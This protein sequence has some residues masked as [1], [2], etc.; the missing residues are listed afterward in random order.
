[1]DLKFYKK[2]P[3]LSRLNNIN[4]MKHWKH[5]GAKEHRLCGKNDFYK[6]YPEFNLEDYKKN[7]Q[8]KFKNDDFYLLNWHHYDTENFRN[9]KTNL[10]KISR[11]QNKLMQHCNRLYSDKNIPIET[12]ESLARKNKLKNIIPIK[13][14]ENI[15]NINAN[16]KNENKNDNKDISTKSN[17]IM[18]KD[19][20][21][22]FYKEYSDL[23]KFNGRQLSSHW[24]HHGQYENRIYSKEH[25]Y[26]I[27]PYFDIDRFK[28]LSDKNYKNDA[29]IMID[30]YHNGDKTDKR[31]YSQIYNIKNK[32]TPKCEIFRNHTL[33][34]KKIGRSILKEKKEKEK[35]EK[36]EKEKKEKEKIEKYKKMIENQVKQK[37]LKSKQEQQQLQQRQQYENKLKELKA[38]DNKID[39]II[40]NKN[41]LNKIHFDIPKNK[42]IK[43]K[44]I[45]TE[46]KENIKL[47][48]EQKELINDKMFDINFY[49]KYWDLKQMNIEQLINHWLNFGQ[50]ENRLGSIAH[51]KLLYPHFNL[52]FFKSKLNEI[53]SEDEYYYIKKHHTKIDNSFSDSITPKSS[54][55]KE[56]FGF[57]MVRHITNAKTEKYWLE[58]Y[59]SIRKHYNNKIIIIDD[60][61]NPLYVKKYDNLVNVEIIQAEEKYRKRA[62]LLPY[63][64]FYKYKFFKKAIIT[65][66][67]VFIRKKI[68]FS[69]INSVQFLW[70]F[71]LGGE[72]IE[73]NELKFI[74]KLE[75]NAKI[76]ELYNDKSK[77]VGCFGIQSVITV[78][79]IEKLQSKYN[80]FNLLNYVK[81]RKDRMCIERVFAVLC[82][83]EEENLKKKPSMFGIIHDY[84]NWGYS[85][86]E[87]KR[88]EM[89]EALNNFPIIKVWTGR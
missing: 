4:L 20:D 25:F 79:F 87:Y 84:L 67:S 33:R 81:C 77:W 55:I 41:K 10:N 35:K 48:S 12:A 31:F 86:R 30:W 54:N 52:N 44:V 46:I 71:R 56:D 19:V 11:E 65:H 2:Y 23:K 73:Y 18:L 7:C 63:Y 39:K 61:S 22:L 15:K 74:D 29:E 58:Y 40:L 80:F 49:N 64:Y 75:N 14:D 6:M 1:M 78:N 50:F 24:M 89:I 45:K 36:E 88:D 53:Y 82:F 51:F 69:N 21:F 37:I 8:I 5:H 38:I 83:I 70:H 17:K 3:D 85:F 9:S 72:D 59:N 57:I 43:K 60:N 47:S 27:Y 16:K 42:D 13:K 66:D 32:N 26:S 28:L 62:E 68:D 76:K 34:I